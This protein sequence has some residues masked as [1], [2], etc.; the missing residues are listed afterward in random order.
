MNAVAL[1]DLATVFV[2][3]FIK[4]NSDTLDKYYHRSRTGRGHYRQSSF[5]KMNYSKRRKLV[6]KTMEKLGI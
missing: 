1:E 4:L 6:E 3:E 5:S 2:S